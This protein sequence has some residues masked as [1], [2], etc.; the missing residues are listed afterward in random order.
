MTRRNSPHVQIPWW[1][2][3]MRDGRFRSL[4]LALFGPLSRGQHRKDSI[5]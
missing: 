3:T 2:R 5:W 1:L 4:L